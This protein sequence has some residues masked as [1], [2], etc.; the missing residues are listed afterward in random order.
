[1]IFKSLVLDNRDNRGSLDDER[2]DTSPSERAQYPTSSLGYR[3][4]SMS[5]TALHHTDPVTESHRR[6]HHLRPRYRRILCPDDVQLPRRGLHDTG[7]HKTAFNAYQPGRRAR[8]YR[9]AQSGAV[10]QESS[11]QERYRHHRGM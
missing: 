1:M 3:D 5:R 10:P 8:R 4:K 6:A 7:D 2:E 9:L 11:P